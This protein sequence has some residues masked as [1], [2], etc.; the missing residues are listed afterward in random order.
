[1]SAAQTILGPIL[2]PRPDGRV[3]FLPD[4]AIACDDSGI[5]TS[6]GPAEAGP[7]PAL[8]RRSRGLILPPFLDAHIHIPQHPIRG[9]FMDG[10]NANPT[11]GRLLA[12]LNR[13]VFPTEAK[14]EDASYT[15]A[16]LEDFANAT[17]ANA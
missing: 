11:E 10:V 2:I 1:M 16:I 3:D 15:A 4:G 5:I 6:I 7:P 13:N 8:S 9:H 14:C 12:G 17:L